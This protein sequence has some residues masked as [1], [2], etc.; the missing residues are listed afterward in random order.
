MIE[1][2]AKEQRRKAP[3]AGALL[4]LLRPQRRKLRLSVR[5]LETKLHTAILEPSDENLITYILAQK[6]LMDQSQRFSEAGKKL[7]LIL[8]L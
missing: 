4:P 6:A 2:Q 5:T 3:P 1:E 8:H 7:F